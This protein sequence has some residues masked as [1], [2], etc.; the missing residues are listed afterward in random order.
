MQNKVLKT[1]VTNFNKIDGLAEAF[2][3]AD[4]IALISMPFVGVKRQNAHK[5]VI[6][7]AKEAAKV[8]G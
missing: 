6:D 8:S 4:K 3:N 7:A 5:N 2:T 1:H